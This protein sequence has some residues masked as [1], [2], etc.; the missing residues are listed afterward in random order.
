MVNAIPLQT[1][2][3]LYEIHKADV[4]QRN[5]ELIQEFKHKQTS[6][7]SYFYHEAPTLT[8]F[9][10]VY[11]RPVVLLRI[12]KAKELSFVNSMEHSEIAYIMNG[13]ITS[14]NSLEIEQRVQRIIKRPKNKDII[15][16]LKATYLHLDSSDPYE[17]SVF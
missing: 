16:K 1:I 10:D 14:N 2:K 8:V 15:Q 6:P 5:H 11:L 7:A 3:V 13:C 12:I 9:I 4:D 17:H